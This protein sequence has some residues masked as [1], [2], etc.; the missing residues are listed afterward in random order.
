MIPTRPRAC[1]R[2]PGIENLK[3]DLS[4]ADAAF[5][6]AIDCGAP[7]QE[8][9]KAAGI[10]I[11]V[12]R[13]PER[14]L[15][16]QC[17]AQEAVRAPPTGRGRPTCDWMFTTAYAA[18]AAWNDT[19]WKNPRFNELLVAA[20]AETDDNKR[21]GMYAEMQQLVHDD[22]GL[23][24]LV[25]NSYV[26]AHSKNARPWRDRRQLADRRHEDRRALVV[27]LIGWPLDDVVGGR[28]PQSPPAT[29]ISAGADAVGS[30]TIESQARE[31][32]ALGRAQCIRSLERFC[33][34]W[35]SGS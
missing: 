32:A 27:R 21:A 26:D 1:S 18:D 3:V 20:R 6:G 22:G 9:A 15:L 34:V 7:W 4:V 12:I 17:L 10:D 14:R 2:R 11:N 25:F 8:H 29:V 5:T 28:A 30:A 24:N 33:S 31:E 23:I 35:G 13:E 16:G 19:F